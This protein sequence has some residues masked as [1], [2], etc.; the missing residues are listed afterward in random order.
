M[1]FSTLSLPTHRFDGERVTKLIIKVWHANPQ[2]LSQLGCFMPPRALFG[3][4][5][6]NH[7][8]KNNAK[9]HIR[10]FMV[11]VI[12][13]QLTL[14]KFLPQ[15]GHTCCPQ[16]GGGAFGRTAP[17]PPTSSAGSLPSYTTVGMASSGLSHPKFGIYSSRPSTS[18]WSP[19]WHGLEPS[20]STARDPLERSRGSS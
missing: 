5:R 19:G 20:N 18:S 11:R 4:R 6:Y 16:S 12:E 1:R 14:A 17:F 2:S 9:A 7:N 15:I 3:S 13:M 10:V 8:S